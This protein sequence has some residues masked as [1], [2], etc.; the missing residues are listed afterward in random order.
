MTD[1]VSRVLPLLRRWGRNVYAFEALEPGLHHWFAP[2]GDAVVAFARAAGWRVG[3]GAPICPRER[4]AEM[5]A[6]FSDDARRHGERAVFFGVSDRFLETLPSLATDAVG[7]DWV[8]IGMQPSWDPRQWGA[9]MAGAPELRRRVRRA[10]KAGITVSEA[11]WH[12]L[13]EGCPLRLEAERLLGRWQDGHA[14]PPM[15]FMVTVDLFTALDERRFFIARQGER[16][17]G[18]LAGVPIYGRQGWLLDD[19]LVDR[20]DAPGTSEA[21]IDLAFATLGAEGV[22]YASLGLVALAGRG[23]GRPSP[24]SHPILEA[25]FSASVRWLNSLYSFQGI[26]SFRDKLQPTAWEPVYMVARSRVHVLTLVG[27]LSAFSDGRP[28]T[29]AARLLL[30]CVRTAVEAVRTL[31]M[32]RRAVASPTER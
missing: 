27:V 25:A 5:A 23:R 30:R 4:L 31:V 14:M 7:F 8:Q 17:V 32:A 12:D 3:V 16:L 19:L 18:L 28:L 10:A 15:R 21:L 22:P 20:Q 6:A 13:A 9:I 29:F 11:R 1:V 24:R 2:D 26:Y